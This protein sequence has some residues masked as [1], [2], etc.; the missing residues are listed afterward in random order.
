MFCIFMASMTQTTWPSLTSSPTVTSM[1]T[2]S[3][4]MGEI[5]MREVSSGILAGR[6]WC[7]SAETG[8][9]TRTASLAARWRMTKPSAAG[10]AVTEN[11]LPSRRPLN[12]ARPGRQFTSSSVRTRPSSCSA[13][14]RTPP[15]SVT[16]TARRRLPTITTQ[17]S[18]VR[19][20]VSPL[21]I[22]RARRARV[23]CIQAAA[24]VTMSA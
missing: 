17:S 15:L 7:K 5:T 14:V 18:R 9:I 1:E 12:K 21:P 2:T 8:V 13:A 23:R 20:E 11:A 19:G 6:R 22:R 3:P 10:A 16:R 4:G 24:A